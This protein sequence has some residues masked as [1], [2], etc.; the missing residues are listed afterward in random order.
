MRIRWF[1]AIRVYGLFLVMGYHLFQGIF[2]GGFLGVEIFFTVSGYLTTAVIIEE[3][4]N[5]DGFSIMRFYKRRAQR[6]M[7]PL[8]FMV[9][10]T[11]P[12]I[13]L[14]SPD[15]MVNI[16]QKAAAALSFTTNWAEIASGGSYEAQLLPSMYIHT[17]SLAIEMQF[18]IVWG[19]ICAG[20]AAVAE[21]FY[22]K[23]GNKRV[24]FFKT[25]I[26]IVSAVLAVGS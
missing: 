10:F 5:K 7:I 12:L 20:L 16:A 17:W 21:Y 26:F 24:I 25:L 6:I 14:I 4:R 18:Y 1:N 13:L 22:K 3:M 9:V 15:F 23:S 19:L 8:V 11:L 2:P